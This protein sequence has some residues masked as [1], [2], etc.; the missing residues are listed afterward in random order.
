MVPMRAVSTVMMAALAPAK[1]RR[2]NSRRSK[3]GE[4]VRSSHQTQTARSAAAAAKRPKMTPEVQPQSLPWMIASVRQKSPALTRPTPG[5]SSGSRVR[6]AARGLRTPRRRTSASGQDDAE[7]ADRDVEPEDGRPAPALDEHAAEHGSG[8]GGGRAERAEQAGREALPLVRE[9]LEQQGQRRGHHGRG[10]DRLHHAPGD[11]RVHRP[12]ERAPDRGGREQRE[13][14]HE[15]QLVAVAVGEPAHRQ[16]EDGEHQVVAVHHP[17]DRDHGALEAADDQR[18]GDAH[19]GGVR[20][21]EEDARREGED[22]QPGI[23]RPGA[24]AG[25]PARRR[26]A[27]LESG[28]CGRV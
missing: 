20:Q 15:Q 5:Q 16:E 24:P 23:G 7:R 9:R 22:D 26:A 12:G 3:S 19:H 6:R 28:S 27:V 17:R 2:P 18:H 10:A 25:R 14:E 4:A 11:E 21:R 8:R 1:V 13:A